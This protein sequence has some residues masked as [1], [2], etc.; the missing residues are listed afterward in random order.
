MET[1]V[2]Y[3]P[4]WLNI[5]TLV[6]PSMPQN[7]RTFRIF[8]SVPGRVTLLPRLAWEFF[9]ERASFPSFPG[10]AFPKIWILRFWHQHFHNLIL[11]MKM[12]LVS[13]FGAPGRRGRHCK[14]GLMRFCTS[15]EKFR[16]RA[17]ASQARPAAWALSRNFAIDVQNL[18]RPNL[19]CLLRLRGAPK[20]ETKAIFVISGSSLIGKCKNIKINSFNVAW[21]KIAR[22]HNLL[23][24]LPTLLFPGKKTKAR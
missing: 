23:Y 12:T 11:I 24:T 16:E 9:R 13:G 21:H 1:K 2:L 10:H 5:Q 7:N 17:Q 6:A 20:P 18:I 14:F 22:W 19:K 3:G 15:K 8:L 4:R